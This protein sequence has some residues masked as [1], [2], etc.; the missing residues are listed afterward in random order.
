MVNNSPNLVTLHTYVR[1]VSAGHR[2]RTAT[3]DIH[4]DESDIDSIESV[5]R[6]ATESERVRKKI[7]ILMRK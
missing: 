4:S 6:L 2:P 3:F 5:E 1:H 7:R